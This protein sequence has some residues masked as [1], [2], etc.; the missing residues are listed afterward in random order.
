MA[1]RFGILVLNQISVSGLSRLP[2]ERYSV[3]GDITGPGYQNTADRNA[4]R[5]NCSFDLRQNA[6]GSCD[7]CSKKSWSR[8]A[9]VQNP[10]A[11][12][13]QGGPKS[14]VTRKRTIAFLT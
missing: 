1:E 12:Y 9:Q 7:E 3:G 13:S 11:C 6:N 2:V 14:T 10:A 8:R 5:G 4:D